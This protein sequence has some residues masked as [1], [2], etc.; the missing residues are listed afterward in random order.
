MDTL[1]ISD[2]RAYGYTG[3]LP[4]ETVLGQWF[5]VD[6]TLA[7]DLSPAG[8]SD[9]LTDTH[10]YRQAIAAVHH[11]IQN[12]PF[13]LIETLASEIARAVLKTD[14]R[15]TQISVK[16]TKLTPPI[17]GFTGN[18]AVEITRDRTHLNSVVPEPLL[19]S[20]GQ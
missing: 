2:I 7:M 8:T 10:D 3:A 20:V 11:L 19:S 6:L 9:V 12:Q 16:L 1:Q 17:P 14:E 5:R 13:K 4:E 18:I 15:L